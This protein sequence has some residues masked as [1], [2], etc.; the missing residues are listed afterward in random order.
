MRISKHI[1]ILPI[2]LFFVLS[3]C[4][5]YNKIVK[6]NDNELKKVK[7]LE[8]FEAKEYIKSLTLLEDIIPFYK[9]TPEGERLY[10]TYCMANYE[11]GDYYLSGYYFKRFIRQYPSSKNLEDAQFLSAM[12]A[13][14]NSPNY[15]LDQTETYNALDELQIFID[16]YPNSSRI[17]TSNQIMDR[18]RA[19]LELKQFEY[20]K[21]YYHTENYKAAV[22]AFNEVL[23]KFPESV[24]KEEVL[25]LLVKSNY[26]LAINS[27]PSKKSD[28]L[29][30]TMKS[31]SKFVAEFP[32]SERLKELNSIKSKTEK[33]ISILVGNDEEK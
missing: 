5:E 22:V 25:Y 32:N 11:L 18:L 33:E 8:Y 26:L 19:K 3:S 31:Y 4:T 21:L 12:C 15:R 24:Y 13:V 10:Y 30:A 16:M 6:S 2:L 14:H 1:I 7:A 9:L 27:I 20:A 29:Y 28:R 23:D 17:D